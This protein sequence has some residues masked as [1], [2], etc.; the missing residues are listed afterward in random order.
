MHASKMKPGRLFRRPGRDVCFWTRRNMGP[1]L[2][3]GEF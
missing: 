2:K 1:G 3:G